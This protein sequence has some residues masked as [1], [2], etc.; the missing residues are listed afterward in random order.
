MPFIP[1]ISTHPRGALSCTP[2]QRPGAS[3]SRPRAAPA[4]ALSRRAALVHTCT[5]FSL[6]VV[7][8]GS[9]VARTGESS[10]EREQEIHELSFCVGLTGDQCRARIESAHPELRVFV[11][12]E[13]TPVTMDY[14]L[15]RVRVVV[16]DDGVVVKPPRQG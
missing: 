8:R 1:P 6:G 11:I 13:R 9:V 4:T 15:D 10:R 16:D 3:S 12:T 7:A 5:L 14:R 2:P